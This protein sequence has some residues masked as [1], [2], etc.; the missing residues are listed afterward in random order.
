MN[1][2]LSLTIGLR[3]TFSKKRNHFISFISVL[4]MLGIAL[5]VLVLIT[6]LSVMNGFDEQIKKKV[7]SM[8]PTATI[9]DSAG[10]LAYQADLVGESE[11]S[12]KSDGNTNFINQ[13]K[14]NT[15][16]VQS[17]QP[18]IN[19]QAVL[20]AGGSNSPSYVMGIEPS[21]ANT[22][23]Q[24]DDKMLNGS[25]ANLI[26]GKY[27][28]V[29]GQSVAF[30][31]GVGVGDKVLL[32]TPKINWSLAGAMPRLKRFTVVGVFHA[33]AGLGYDDGVVFINIRDAQVLYHLN[34]KITG[35]QVKLYDPFEVNQFDHFVL[36]YLP[37]SVALTDWT[38]QYGNFFHAVAM[39]KT[40]MFLILLLIIAVAIFNLVSMLVMLVN[41][42]Q[43]DIAILRTL[44]A[45][46][47]LILRIFIAQ[48]LILGGLGAL[49]GVLG[50]I[51]LSRHVTQ[52]VD[53]L[54]KVLH[55]NFISADVYFIDYLPSKLIWSDVWHIV[56]IT[57][58]FS[59]LATLYPA[60]R[61]SK[62]EPAKALR[63][64]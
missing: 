26:P 62:I 53:S 28:I 12:T 46:K 16:L 55:Q 59:F 48:G 32:L 10:S 22:I 9:T 25:F 56:I 30:N 33:G 5:G 23:T 6:V 54:Q 19:G 44:G 50:G 8:V 21:Y 20:Q 41:E 63:Y 57:V 27:G 31:L 47:Y 13:I 4:S 7:F 2:L 40:M 51:F 35:Y 34:D 60:Y 11:V 61:A 3:Y 1:K 43:S 58:I 64:E 52:F 42:K 49:L 36:N 17:I 38:N 45:S 24:L 37:T 29:L 14:S 18:Y 39:E 15:D